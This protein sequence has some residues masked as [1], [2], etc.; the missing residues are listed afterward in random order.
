MF[1]CVIHIPLIFCKSICLWLC[2]FK[3]T[4]LHS[5][6][7]C[8]CVAAC[9]CKRVCVHTNTRG[10]FLNVIRNEQE[11]ASASGTAV[12]S[13]VTSV[14]MLPCCSKETLRQVG[15]MGWWATLI[16]QRAHE[17]WKIVIMLAKLQ[18][19][20]QD[21]CSISSKCI[22]NLWLNPHCSFFW[23]DHLLHWQL[24]VLLF[25]AIFIAANEDFLHWSFTTGN[26]FC[27][28][29]AQWLDSY[30]Q[31]RGPVLWG[32]KPKFYGTSMLEAFQ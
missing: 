12:V 20:R 8:C 2:V 30:W 13:T 28:I 31:S 21:I 23:N 18:L 10:A 16:R 11:A 14:K 1:V 25:T 19:A 4:L 5:T 27:S 15:I 26:L 24:P 17:G 3:E 6:R 9:S 7:G 32:A 22:T 29:D